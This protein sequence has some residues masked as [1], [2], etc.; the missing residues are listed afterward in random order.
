MSG[1]ERNNI[2]IRSEL[3]LRQI[4]KWEEYLGI[5]R[6]L[7]FAIITFTITHTQALLAITNTFITKQKQ[8]D[9]NNKK[10]VNRLS[11]NMNHSGNPVKTWF[12]PKHGAW[13]IGYIAT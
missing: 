1:T 7:I 8:N 10:S 12:Q 6:F 13:G 4:V 5:F 11:S 9:C 3:I 2:F